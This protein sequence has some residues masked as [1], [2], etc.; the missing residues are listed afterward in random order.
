MNK[1][2]LMFSFL[3]IMTVTASAQSSESKKVEEKEHDFCG[4]PDDTSVP[5][6]FTSN[7]K[8]NSKTVI[9]QDDK[10]KTEKIKKDKPV[11]ND[12]KV[13]VKKDKIKKGKEGCC[14]YEVE[15]GKPKS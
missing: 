9:M 12:G 10:G 15:E 11:K 2:F 7:K 8:D 4:V 1:F 14:D 3:F 6:V 5:M 13:D